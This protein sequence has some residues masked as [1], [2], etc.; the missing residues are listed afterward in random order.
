MAN[1][2]TDPVIGRATR[3]SMPDR[4]I[5]LL[6]MVR[7][8]EMNTL[9]LELIEEIEQALD[10]C[11]RERARAL[12]VTGQDRAFC[13][14]AHLQY[15]AGDA[16]RFLDPQTARDEYLAKIA[17]AFDRLE[18]CP[19]PTIAAVNGYA[20]GGGFE[21]ALS[22]DMRILA[23]IA[24]VGLPETRL[25][26]IAGAGGVQK[27]IRHVGRSKALEW[28]LRGAHIDAVTAERHGLCVALAPR[29]RVVDEA[30]ALARELRA[31]G[32]QAVAQSKA[33]IYSAEDTDLRTARRYG[34]DALSMM[35]GGREWSEGMS[36][37]VEKRKPEFDQW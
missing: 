27:L 32:P 20:L 34:I 15:F 10:T 26:A 4:G 16:P 17:R 13:C 1:S 21:M 18:E 3:L 31:L 5:W 33:T 7:G 11:T 14:G 2:A 8:R 9:T 29:D 23:Q 24:I 37:F 30:L 6:E 12:V 19:F 35:V 28:T 36:A 25:G 22:C